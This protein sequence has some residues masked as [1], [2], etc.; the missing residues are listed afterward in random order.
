MGKPSL[1]INGAPTAP[2]VYALTHWPGGR[3]SW[4]E[5]PSAAIRSMARAGIR[6][7]QVEMR[8]A[9]L[10]QPDGS[11]DLDLARRQARGVLDICPEAVIFFRLHVDPTLEWD[12]G[13]PE[14]MTV[15]SD[16][17]YDEEVVFGGCI[18][19]DVEVK[20]ARRVSLVSELWR[21]EY[22]EHL[23][24]FCREFAETPE[25]ASL[26]GIHVAGGL[27]AEWHMW[28]FIS[29][30]PDCGPAMTAWF[31]RWLRAKY[32]TDEALQAA[33][34]SPEAALDS[35]EMPRFSEWT[36]PLD[37]IFIDPKGGHR[38][39]DAHLCQHDGTAATIEHFCRIVKESWPRDIVTGVFY[40]YFHMLFGRMA[41]GGHL[42][43]ERLV[44]SPWI[45]YF[46]APMSYWGPHRSIGGSGQARGLVHSCLLN[47]K[48]WLDEYDTNT[49]L[50][51]AGKFCSFPGLTLEDDVALMR[52][53]S[54]A[55]F[56]KGQGF[57]HYDFGARDG[58]WWNHPRLEL[59]A[60]ALASL[61]AARHAWPY[62]S[63]ADVL[64]IH[65][66]K[67]APARVARTWND[68]CV[69]HVANDE[70][71]ASLA[72]TGA[73]HDQASLED[74]PSL[75]ASQ[76]RLVV[77]ANTW[78]LTPGQ[79]QWAAGLPGHVLFNYLPGVHDGTSLDL[80]FVEE[81]TGF[82]LRW[83][84]VLQ[85]RLDCRE[86]VSLWKPVRAAEV[87]DGDPL[88]A[89]GEGGA[90]GFAR[91]GSRWFASLPLASLAELAS[92]VREAGCHVYC[93]PGDVVLAGH[94]L[95]LLHTAQAGAKQ[96]RLR[97]GKV[98]EFE[99]ASPSTTVLDSTTGE[100]LLA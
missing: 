98:V 4:E 91:K 93:E 69:S 81:A 1:H 25:G 30:E 32:Q 60:A 5:M 78:V 84:D 59:E 8:L 70:L 61:M 68:D 87:R 49:S 16:G 3:W 28:G 76:Y 97:S 100:L 26:G 6:L 77:F 74:L 17:P 39:V 73:L 86:P 41:A 52:R 90:C 96:V 50:M 7:Y 71:T 92:I 23:A 29:H 9:W 44:R 80:A 48:L 2:S 21:R 72:K 10:L 45:D 27:F 14:E 55:A 42:E 75:D 38:A 20:R 94:G 82:S 13:H 35:A 89:L 95:V 65:D 63:E 47:G 46:S 37:G 22:G 24:R 33:W 15:Y 58:G 85:G 79:R 62:R 40:G 43:F 57:W 53:N 12:A 18:V 34:G 36:P 88:A 67:H 54:L 56:L 51:Q 11:L 83:S 66:V 99:A 19:Q 64:V 31:R